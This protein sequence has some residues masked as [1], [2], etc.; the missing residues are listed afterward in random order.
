MRNML[1]P[2]AEQFGGSIEEGTM[3]VRSPG[4]RYV[5]PSGFYARW[6]AEK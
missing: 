5:L 3:I 6:S 1:V 2:W 4:L